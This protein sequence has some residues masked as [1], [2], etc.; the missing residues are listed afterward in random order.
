MQNYGILAKNAAFWQITGFTAFD[1]N[2]D[3]HDFRVSV[4]FHRP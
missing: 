4:I 2:H 1:E 3:F